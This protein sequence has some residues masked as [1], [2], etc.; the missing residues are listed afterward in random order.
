MKIGRNAPCPCGSGKKYKRCCLNPP[1]EPQPPA[2]ARPPGTPAGMDTELG[3][4][5]ERAYIH[6]LRDKERK[7]GRSTLA[8]L[9]LEVDALNGQEPGTTLEELTRPKDAGDAGK[10]ETTDG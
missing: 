4:D 9:T 1:P 7:K 3:A 6:A 2:G 5:E 10:K 8:V